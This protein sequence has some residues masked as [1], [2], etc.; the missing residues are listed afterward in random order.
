MISQNP[1]GDLDETMKRM[2]DQ[3]I[4]NTYG[5]SPE[6]F[7]SLPYEIQKALMSSYWHMQES[8]N[9][10]SNGKQEE[11]STV[12]EKHDTKVDKFRKRTAL[13]QYEFEEN[14]KRKVLSIFKK[15]QEE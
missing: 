4:K 13:K 10:E 14:V 15:K 3:R 7:Y 2:S 12:Q 9:Q 8:Y 11:M 5:I 6:L 1:F